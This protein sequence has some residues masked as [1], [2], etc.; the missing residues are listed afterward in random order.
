[1]TFKLAQLVSLLAAVTTERDREIVAAMEPNPVYRLL[2]E[3]LDDAMLVRSDLNEMT[4][5]TV[6]EL[7]RTEF[8][9]NEPALP[10][11]DYPPFQANLGI[12]KMRGPFHRP[13]LAQLS[14]QD[15]FRDKP[16]HAGEEKA[17]R[18]AA[19]KAR[20]KNRR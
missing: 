3:A 7:N 10:P 13:S 6:P 15:R 4:I 12:L 11:R 17:K 8:L 5:L 2:S 9:Y 20:A 19:K 14:F 1:M 16:G 18:K